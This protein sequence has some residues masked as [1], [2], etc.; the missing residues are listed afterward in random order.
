M[1]KQFRQY[2]RSAE[3][4]HFYTSKQENVRGPYCLSSIS[5]SNFEDKFRRNH[6]IRVWV[7]LL[8]RYVYK[9]RS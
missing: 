4:C 5:V 2:L 3:Q 1:T 9:R 8:D 6:K 7:D